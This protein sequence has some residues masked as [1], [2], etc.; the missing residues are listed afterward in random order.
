MMIRLD[1][2]AAPS[3]AELRMAAQS[4]RVDLPYV[5]V[6]PLLMQVEKDVLFFRLG[7]MLFSIFGFIAM[8]L[9]AV[10]LYG[11]LV[12]FVTERTLEIGIRRSLGADAR[13][14]LS[15]V[16]RQ[17]M[18]PVAIGLLVGL[19]ASLGGTRFLASLLFG[20]TAR[21]PIS[22]V[23]ASALLIVVATVAALIPARR[24]TRVDPVIAMRAD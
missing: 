2:N 21:D 16:L 20:V 4:V 3:A 12:Y 8:A 10:G 13:S 17:A 18:V 11:M 6:R 5:S 15:L 23:S 24:A 9:S 19:A 14:V 7:A 22:F 1:A